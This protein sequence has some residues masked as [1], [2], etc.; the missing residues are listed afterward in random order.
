[1]E[2]W[3]KAIVTY[4]NTLPASGKVA[5]EA[6]PNPSPSANE[7]KNSATLQQWPEPPPAGIPLP[8]LTLA[9]CVRWEIL[10]QSLRKQRDSQFPVTLTA[11]WSDNLKAISEV[12]KTA[13]GSSFVLFR[14]LRDAIPK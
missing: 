13:A 8:F 12:H 9:D 3:R 10:E 6:V 4:E 2:N 14:A 5:P 1:M 7:D 11:D